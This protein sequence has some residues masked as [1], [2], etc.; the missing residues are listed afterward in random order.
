MNRGHQKMLWSAAS[1]DERAFDDVE[2][3]NGRRY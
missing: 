2:R 3:E 1:D